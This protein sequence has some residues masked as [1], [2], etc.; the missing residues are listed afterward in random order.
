MGVI[1]QRAAGSVEDTKTGSREYP[2]R[3]ND[4]IV[5]ILFPLTLHGSTYT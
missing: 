1:G 5:M 3:V 2:L 4:L